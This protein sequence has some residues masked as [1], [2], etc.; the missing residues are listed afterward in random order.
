MFER[1]APASSLKWYAAGLCLGLHNMP[2]L[3]PSGGLMNS[4]LLSL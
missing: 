3:A 1:E 4:L 2:D